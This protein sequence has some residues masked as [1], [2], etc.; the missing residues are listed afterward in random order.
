[1]K[2]FRKFA[3]SALVLGT[4]GLAACEK[5]FLDVNN[6]PNFPLSSTPDLVLPAGQ[7]SVA[8]VMAGSLQVIGNI[9]AQNWTQS[10]VQ[11]Q[12][13]QFDRYN[14]VNTDFDRQWQSLYSDALA[15]LDYVRRTAKGDSINYSAMAGI[16]EAY[17]YQVLN[18][19][20]G[21]IPFTQSL[22]GSANT[23]PAFDAGPVV[24]DG[25]I[26]LIDESVAKINPAAKA[27]VAGADLVF[28]GDL[29]AWKRFA[30]TLK[31]KIY[32]RQVYA[33]PD[34]ARTGIQ[35]LYTTGA[36]FL[37]G[38]EDADIPFTDA[39]NQQ[40]PLYVVE[41]NVVSNITNNLVASKTA[42]DYLNSLNDP[43]T[44]AFYDRPGGSSTAAH[45][46]VQQG[47]A[48]QQGAPAT[49]N[50]AFSRPGGLVASP[51][52]PFPFISGQESL[53]LQA[54][55]ALRGFATGADE[56][57]LY[58]QAVTASFGQNEVAGD[59]AAYL[60]KP[61]VAYDQTA[62]TE[63]K[64]ERLMTQKW[65][66]LNGRQG[67]EAWTE[68]RRTKYPSF[69]QPSITSV[70]GAGVFPG[71]LPLPISE[72]QRNPNAPAFQRIDTKIWWDKK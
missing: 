15:D 47:L 3:V 31:L 17:T 27:D 50:N 34:V 9:C 18:D 62:N 64:L 40:N 36:Q 19:A 70:F 21:D 29:D 45:V 66:A 65:I 51:T 38:D 71:R 44:D 32:L 12:Y 35:G 72:T 8:Y 63:A 42:I 23:Q 52:T 55:A 10:L 39:L 28:K 25:L 69:I 5:D 54:E 37:S 56:K 59:A 26:R 57:A 20:F 1:M 49:S 67:F 48:A 58:D 46:G 11:N 60:A 14:L 68:F 41:F 53:F 61:E 30:N 7:A 24:Y 6:N 43:R 2:L 13:K 22:Q 4:L 16:M 33:R